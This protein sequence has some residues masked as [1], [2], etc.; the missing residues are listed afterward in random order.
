MKYVHEANPPVIPDFDRGNETA[1]QASLPFVSQNNLNHLS[2]VQPTPP[3]CF[4]LNDWETNYN[5]KLRCEGLQGRVSDSIINTETQR[6][7]LKSD[8]D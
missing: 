5:V 4:W 3:C 6:L 1:D 2:L 7:A 8:Y